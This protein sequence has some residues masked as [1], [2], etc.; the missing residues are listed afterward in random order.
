[1]KGLEAEQQK[2]SLAA[3]YAAQEAQYSKMAIAI[4]LAQAN[5]DL[6]LSLGKTRG[7]VAGAGLAESGSDISLYDF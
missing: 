1:M 5:K 2:Y 3:G 6:Y 4:N 7:E